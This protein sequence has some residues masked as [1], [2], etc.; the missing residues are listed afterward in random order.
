MAGS[1]D[2]AHAGRIV[3]I[4][5]S[6][7]L[8]EI[9]SEAACS[10]CHAAPYCSLSGAVSKIV[11]V[12]ASLG[13]WHEGQEVNVLLKRSMGFKA[14]WL[15]YMIPLVILMAVM[16]LLI[17]LGFGEVLSGLSAIAS[18]GIYYFF[19]W[20]FRDRLRNDYSFYIKEK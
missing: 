16:L 15:A 8:V 6:T 13:D 12:P 11:E 20:L 1:A 19:L 10:S 4:T 2:I 3:G 14:V 9:I 17:H 18:V 5:P 7:I